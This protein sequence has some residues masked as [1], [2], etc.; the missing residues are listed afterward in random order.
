MSEQNTA[1]AGARRWRWWV[2]A[3]LLCLVTA[4]LGCNPIQM[5]NWIITPFM[6]NNAPATV[7]LSLPDQESKVCIIVSHDTML[8]EQSFRD[9]DNI[10]ASRLASLLEQRY[11][12]NGNKIKVVAVGK[13]MKYARSHPDW[14]VEPK[15]KLAKAF[16]ADFL[17]YCEVGHLSLYEQGSSMSLFRG[18]AQID[19]KVFDLHTDD[20][21][22]KW[23]HLQE[24][25]YPNSGP[26]DV[27]PGNSPGMFRQRFLERVAKDL[28]QY[29][30]AHPPK[31]KFEAD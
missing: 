6:D 12:E 20:D 18:Q 15:T 10:L 9:A 1:W 26:E 31:D 24:W 21:G 3:V 2:A 30:A 27:G 19:I 13:A 29:F 5:T 25:L 22:Y 7:D 28:S 17:I 16:D 11:K 14:L 4:G 23:S 8:P